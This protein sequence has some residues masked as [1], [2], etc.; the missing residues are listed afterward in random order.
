MLSPRP[1]SC[2]SPN[3]DRENPSKKVQWTSEGR[4]RR[5]SSTDSESRSHTEPCR[6][7]RSRRPSRLTVKYDWGQLQRWLEMEQWVDAQVQELF[8]TLQG[9]SCQAAEKDCSQQTLI[10]KMKQN[11]LSWKLTWR[12]SWNSPQRSR[13]LSWRAFS[14]TAPARPSLLSLSCSV[15][16][17]NFGDSAGL[18]NKPGETI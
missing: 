4:R 2:T 11:L 18:K 14:K 13:R 1:H 5:T 10:C 3:L 16:S 7:A 9:T 17:K 12:L 6:L 15:N 8:Q